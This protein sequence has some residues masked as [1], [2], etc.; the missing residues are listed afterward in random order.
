M[1][2]LVVIAAALLAAG[3]AVGVAAWQARLALATWL[4]HQR[5]L[6]Q[7]AAPAASPDLGEVLKRLDAL[8]LKVAQHDVARL[9][10][11]R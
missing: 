7:P 5:Q 2:A 10:G 8:E 1:T 6:Q 11:R 4:E 9:T 3:V